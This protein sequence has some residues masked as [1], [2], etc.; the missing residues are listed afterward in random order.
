VG[1]TTAICT[2]VI[3]CHPLRLARLRGGS[4][5]SGPQSCAVY[6]AS[7]P[8]GKTERER[9][10]DRDRERERERE[11]GRERPRETERD[12]ERQRETER[13]RPHWNI[14]YCGKP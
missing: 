7:K 11:R 9:E 8:G 13:E 6:N 10:R 12:R 1:S 14:K 2:M 3:R 5:G 4:N